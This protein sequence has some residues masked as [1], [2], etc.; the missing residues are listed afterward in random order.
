MT[1]PQPIDSA[2]SAGVDLSNWRQSPYNQWAFANVSQLVDCAVIEAGS[3][4]GTALPQAS[5]S[6]DDVWLTDEQGRQL[7]LTDALQATATDGFVVLHEGALL[8]E[9]YAHGHSAD[10]RHIL[11]SVSKSV[12]GLIAGQL[13][14]QGCLDPQANVTDYVPE[15][16]DTAYR[17]VSVRDLLDMRVGLSMQAGQLTAYRQ[18]MGWDPV[19]DG[20]RRPTQQDFL[21]HL[22][23]RATG[24]GGAFS[25]ISANTDL[26]GWVLE[27]A[28][29]DSFARLASDGLWQP[30]GAAA[31]AQITVDAAGSARA[32][33][34]LCA[35]T[36]DLA[37][38]GQLLVDGGQRAGQQIVPTDWWHDIQHNGDREAWDNGEF[39][40]GFAGLPMSYRSGWYVIHGETPLLF[41][42][43]IHGQH[44]FVDPAL[45]L[46]VAKVSSLAEPTDP[47]AIARTLRWVN[48]I[49]RSLTP[50]S[51]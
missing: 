5:E 51:R 44:L 33:G 23:A 50:E 34:G 22:K 47:L 18:A 31:D 21:I 3:D 8:H 19:A 27:R 6:L 20:N 38:L 45:E 14:D 37:R 26:L 16:T 25:Y 42:M 17:D 10:T 30:M 13:V 35:T 43:G 40:A 7:A 41:A 11:M 2:D 32:A 28:A 12:T 29:G 15:M 39:A 49:R 9:Y 36:R 4:A 48:E 1:R 24:H 46:V